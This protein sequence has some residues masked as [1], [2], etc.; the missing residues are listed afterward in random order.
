MTWCIRR[1]A[2]SFAHQPHQR[3]C[4]ADIHYIDVPKFEG[5]RAFTSF[6]QDPD[7]DPFASGARARH[8][9]NRQLD[10]GPPSISEVSLPC[11]APG[12]LE[13]ATH[14]LSD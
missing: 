4:K 8:A 5:C 13:R 2:C 6:D 12:R 1:F 10:R 7:L 3:L 9:P 14:G 11:A